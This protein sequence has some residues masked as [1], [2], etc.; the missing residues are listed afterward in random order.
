MASHESRV[1]KK[2]FGT[3]VTPTNSPVSPEKFYGYHVGTDFEIFS[4]EE[5]SEVE[6]DA[7]CDGKLAI[8]RTASGYGGL[9]AQYC[10]LDGSPVL[11]LYGHL[12]L[13]SVP[14]AIGEE[15]KAGDKLGI[16]GQPGVETDN[17]RKHLHLAIL[18]G[19]EISIAGYVQ[20]KASLSAYV[21]PLS[22]IK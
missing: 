6:V 12:D 19:H 15:I 20:D 14:A 10:V 22:V 5:T 7:V 18:K 1:T 16:L 2:S 8:K 3:F 11:V 4:G 13:A 21:D 9:V 17:E